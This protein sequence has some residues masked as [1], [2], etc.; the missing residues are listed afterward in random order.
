MAGGFKLSH[1]IVIILVVG[2]IF[3]IM[4]V[5]Y[6]AYTFHIFGNN[7]NDVANVPVA[8]KGMNAMKQVKEIAKQQNKRLLDKQQDNH[9]SQH[10]GKTNNKNN[11]K[12]REMDGQTYLTICPRYQNYLLKQSC[13]K[14][15]HLMFF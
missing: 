6:I 5:G 3:Q 2:A 14:M 7:N 1:G 12:K 15:L 8:N 13:Q 9:K 11:K 4:A 10:I